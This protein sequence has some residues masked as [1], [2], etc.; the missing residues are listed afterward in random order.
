[1]TDLINIYEIFSSIQGESTF[2]GLPFTFIRVAGCNLKCSWCDTVVSQDAKSGQMMDIQTILE[3]VRSFGNEYVCITGGEPLLQPGIILLAEKLRQTSHT[4][5]IETN[6]TVDISVIPAGIHRIVDFKCPSS[7]MVDSIR[8]E[9]I[10]NL[11]KADEV[12]FVISDQTDFRFAAEFVRTKLNNFQ[13]EVLFSPV[14]ANLNPAVLAQWVLA[15]NL[16]VRINL[17][18]HKILN[19]P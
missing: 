13:G 15:E 12:K 17:Q 10:E 2:S 5:T 14:I 16:V 6:G 11:R 8:M 9:N 18:L 19:L 1:M 3:Q 7:G 4:I